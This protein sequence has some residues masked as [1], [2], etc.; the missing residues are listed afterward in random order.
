MCYSKRDFFAVYRYSPIG[1]SCL[2]AGSL[3]VEDDLGGVIRRI[4]MF[5]VGVTI[6]HVI[7]TF[8]LLP[9]LYVAI[10]R[11][12]PFRHYARILEALAAGIAPPSK[13]VG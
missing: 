10:V 6:S 8:I 2:I 1:V 7:H 11:R 12:N 3:L 9:L 4:A 13:S 5:V